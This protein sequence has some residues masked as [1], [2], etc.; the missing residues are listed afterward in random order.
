MIKTIIAIYPG[1]FQPF[2]RHHAESFKW[3]ESKFGKGKTFIATSDVV[4][5]PKSPLNFKE[6]KEII[7]KYGYGSSLVQVK[8]PYQAQEITQKFDP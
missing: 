1:R 6:K 4:T 5:A 8:N 2:G 7:S 3:L